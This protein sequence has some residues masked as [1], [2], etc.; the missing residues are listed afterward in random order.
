MN[1]DTIPDY[2]SKICWV[3]AKCVSTCIKD[4][5]EAEYGDRAFE[6]LAEL[7]R[8]N[9]EESNRKHS[10]TGRTANGMR[11]SSI[12]QSACGFDRLDCRS[13]AKIL[14]CIPEVGKL[15]QKRFGFDDRELRLARIECRSMILV[16]NT[17]AFHTYESD[18]DRQ[19][20]VWKMAQSAFSVILSLFP[21]VIDRD[22]PEERTYAECMQRLLNAFYSQIDS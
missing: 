15:L 18:S 22:A 13:C 1:I 17:L 11:F 19:Y 16:R 9:C 8:K 6:A 20:A 10:E 4:A 5:M 12:I 14:L 21:D 2:Y 3:F 7:D